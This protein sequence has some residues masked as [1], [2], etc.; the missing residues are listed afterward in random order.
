MFKV[1]KQNNL[2]RG[3]YKMRNIQMFD[4][5][6][7]D[8]EQSP[9]VHL[10]LEEKVEI[11]KQLEALGVD[12]I[13]AGF[14][15]ASPGEVKNVR[16][17]GKVLHHTSV[18]ALS[19]ANRKDIDAAIEGLSTAKDPCLHIVIA[20]SPIHRKHKL[21]MTKEQVIE[22][23]VDAIRYGKKHFDEIEFSLEDASR[24]ESE[25]M[26]AVIDAAIQAGATV[27]NLPDTVGFASPVDF[28][29]MFRNVREHVPSSDKIKLSTHCH[30]DLGMA[31]ANSLA[32]IHGGVDQIEGTI[33]GI[34]ERAGNTAIEEIAL[35]LDTR[36]DIYGATTN[37]N[38]KEIYKTSEL[39][40]KHTGIV[41]QPNKAIVGANA[42]AHEAGIH[43]DGVLKERTTYEIIDPETIGASGTSMIL[44][45]H[46]GRHAL[47][48]KLEELG[49]SL[50][51]GK[52]A[53]VF[54]QFKVAIDEKKRLTDE[55]IR[56]L[57]A[58]A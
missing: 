4:T 47:K 7:R 5:T 10:T 43:Q 30:N 38:T 17:I 48:K 39:V 26:Y 56:S 42:F 11:A 34:G 49:F 1:I 21:N 31:T 19:R 15:I 9:G 36:S 32:A 27:I 2:V 53:E 6:L 12:R 28:G 8:G 41:V 14:P 23:A 35:A 37:I 24:T 3:R 52:L 25:Y 20:T 44:G 57:V 55:E 16:E 46:S 40:R 29:N 18:A 50:E 54:S 13:E 51:D 45:K 58:Q 33:N 22:T